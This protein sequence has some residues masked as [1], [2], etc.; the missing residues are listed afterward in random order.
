LSSF[1]L[2]KIFIKTKLSAEL[3]SEPNINMDNMNEDNMD[4]N[5]DDMDIN[6]NMD[7]SWSCCPCGKQFCAEHQPWM[8]TCCGYLAARACFDKDWAEPTN[9][10]ECPGCNAKR[11]R[12]TPV[13][14]APKALELIREIDTLQVEVTKANKAKEIAERSAKRKSLMMERT[15]SDCLCDDSGVVDFCEDNINVSVKLAS[16][17][18]RAGRISEV[19]NT[20]PTFCGHDCFCGQKLSDDHEPCMTT[21]C[22]HLAARVCFKQWWSVKT[23]KYRCPGCN[24]KFNGGRPPPVYRAPKIL[25]LI[26]KYDSLSFELI[27]VKATRQSSKRKLK[28][29]E[30]TMQHLLNN[31]GVACHGQLPAFEE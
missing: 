1:N 18:T 22:G 9:E 28:M 10:F 20:D 24:T 3:Y 30:K 14:R 31:P 23:N 29:L 2:F 12:P 17:K 26:K 5:M 19:L 16:T 25:E 15:I 13:Y 6:L 4:M 21:C 8:T 11:D 27:H 7:A